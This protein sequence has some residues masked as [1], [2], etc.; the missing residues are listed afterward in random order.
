MLLIQVSGTAGFPSRS[1]VAVTHCGYDEETVNQDTPMWFLAVAGSGVHLNIGKTW[2]GP[3]LHVEEEHKNC[4]DEELN[5][6]PGAP[7]GDAYKAHL[8]LVQGTGRFAR[9][10]QLLGIQEPRAHTLTVPTAHS[11]H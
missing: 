1:W 6:C 11:V 3:V 9:V 8:Y 5:I 2:I 10:E 4:W 7:N